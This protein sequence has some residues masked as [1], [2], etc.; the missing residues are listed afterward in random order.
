MWL[1]MGS[2]AF[3]G[4]QIAAVFGP[5]QLLQLTFVEIAKLSVVCGYFCVQLRCTQ[6]YML[7]TATIGEMIYSNLL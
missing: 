1:K 2:M 4:G 6:Y 5:V 3:H 7:T